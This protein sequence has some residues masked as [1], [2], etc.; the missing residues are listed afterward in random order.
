MRENCTFNFLFFLGLR[1][2]SRRIDYLLIKYTSLA[3]FGLFLDTTERTRI[4]AAR[5]RPSLA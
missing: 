2:R 5:W 4:K 1:I 3:V